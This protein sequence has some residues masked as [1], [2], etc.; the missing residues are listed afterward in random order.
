MRAVSES[1]RQDVAPAL[2]PGL[3][4]RPDVERLR[5]ACR[6]LA[7]AQPVAL[8]LD[9]AR[10][11]T[12]HAL[13]AWWRKREV[14][15][16]LRALPLAPRRLS[17]E[18]LLLAERLADASAQLPLDEAGF[19]LGRAYSTMLPAEYRAA[20]G[21]FYTPPP[22]VER[23]LDNAE[24]AGIDWAKHSVLDPA[25]GGGAFIGPV[26]RRMLR[27]LGRADP[28]LKAR[29]LATRLKGFELDAFSA[30]MT[31][32]FTDATVVEA[33]GELPRGLESLIDVG[34]TLQRPFASTGPFDLVIGN[35]PYG[36]LK[37]PEALRAKF[38]RSLY[39]H[40]NLYGLF[41]DFAVH[42]AAPESGVIAFVT[43]TGFLCGEYFKQ[44]RSV[45]GTR[46]PPLLVD[47]VAER[48]G[49]FDDVLQETL[50]AVFRKGAKGAARTSFVTVDDAAGMSAVSGGTFQVPSPADGPWILP[51]T[52]SARRLAT[53]LRT[54]PSRLSDWGYRVATGPLVWNRFKQRLRHDYVAGAVPLV[55]A[56]SVTPDGSFEFRAARRNHAP[57]F[58]PQPGEEHLLLRKACVLLQRTTAKEQQRR[59]I[60]ALL[61]QSL[62]DKHGAVCVENHLNML[63][64]TVETPPVSPAAL[65][66]FL[67][68]S[69]ADAAFRCISGTV[70]VSAYELEALPLPLPRSL[71]ALERA[72]RRPADKATLNALC[73]ALYE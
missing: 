12:A 71:A 36:R 23:L 10:G 11:V 54:L 44:L 16:R 15:A 24:A 13:A 4:P 7:E 70:A 66:A 20:N 55:W 8:Q 46:A 17:D 67:N 41:L 60:A 28:R 59:L 62:V 56:E 45:L 1:L 26:A 38:S 6:V 53:A 64:P 34:D 49:V 27:A 32:C 39:G 30:W 61:P 35:P 51:R 73:D 57:Y 48:E 21:V 31:G 29:A 18:S 3:P 2:T 43:P 69:A 50:L 58:L 37:L 65:A 33:L 14:Q 5:Q 19:L 63:L 42:V 40:A 47:F 72:V 22:V 25:C 68:S 9:H 52:P